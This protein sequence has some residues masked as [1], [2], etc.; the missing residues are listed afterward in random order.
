MKGPTSRS[1]P[2]L[3][4]PP[5]TAQRLVRFCGAC[6]RVCVSVCMH[7]GT[8]VCLCVAER[9]R[10]CVC[11]CIWVCVCVGVY[12][13]VCVCVRVRACVHVRVRVWL[14][15]FPPLAAHQIVFFPHFVAVCCSDLLQLLTSSCGYVRSRCNG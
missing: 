8:C 6:V 5:L 9:E 4:F 12:V 11:V 7:V 13:G 3:A 1:H 10:E 15:A 2:N 14:L